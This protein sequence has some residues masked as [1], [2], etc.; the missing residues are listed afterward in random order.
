[1]PDYRSN[2]WRTFYYL[3]L[4]Y[5]TMKQYYLHLP[6]WKYIQME[7]FGIN[8]KDAIAHF[9]RQHGLLRMPKG[10]AIWERP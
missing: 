9:K 8:K 6:I 5:E 10:Y 4:E 7:I 1:M 3:L 2:Y